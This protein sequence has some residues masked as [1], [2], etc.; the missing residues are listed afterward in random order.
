MFEAAQGDNVI[1]RTRLGR[2]ADPL[3]V[4]ELEESD[5]MTEDRRTA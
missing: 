3:W 2:A 4:I 1:C 5:I